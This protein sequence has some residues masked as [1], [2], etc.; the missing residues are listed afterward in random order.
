M[1][2][3]YDYIIVGAGSAGCVL[4]NRLSSCGRN[5]V[6][7]V[8]AGPGDD[9]LFIKMPAAFTQAMTKGR[10]DWGYETEPE[11]HLNGRS[12]PCYR[13]RVMGGSSSINAMSFVRGHPADYDAWASEHGL[14]DWSYAKCLPYFKKLETYSEGANEFR[15]G[16]GP[17]NVT[18][19]KLSSPLQSMFL[20]AA[21][22]AGYPTT[23]DT[24]G[25]EQEGFGLNDQMIHNGQRV[26]AATAYI[27]PIKSRK[28]LRIEMGA[29]VEHVLFKNHRAVGIE[30]IQDGQ[31]KKAFSAM[32][33][34]LSAGAINSPKL[35][36][37]SGIGPV[38]HL[39]SLGIDVIANSTEV[40]QNLQDHVDFSIAHEATRPITVSP[41]LRFPKKAMIGI[42]WIL[43]KTGWGATNHFET[44]GYV[45]TND[46][47]S[48]PNV[49]FV[50]VPLLVRPDG[51]AKAR[52]HGFQVTAMLLRPRSRGTVIVKNTAP[53]HPPAIHYDY[54][55]QGGDLEELRE[56]VRRLRMILSQSALDACRGPELSP[57]PDVQS[58]D[59]IDEFIRSNLK[60]TYHPCGTCRMGIDN[61]SVVDAEARVRGV[62]GLRVIDASIFPSVTSGNIN[63][64]TLK[65]A[66]KLADAILNAR[67]APT[68]ILRS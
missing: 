27:H 55:G 2:E 67:P 52:M 7:L 44:V 30:Y 20:S 65:V 66:E 34:I 59:E 17:V 45:R 39:A 33:V 8:E 53:E 14:K 36:V 47:L 9:H 23:K 3:T 56:C 16:D 35:L 5:R 68:M 21:E 41:A 38:D 49:Q 11:Q 43:R 15:G 10:F 22:Q 50:L 54:L 29:M 42:E 32:E 57:G 31:K 28:N 19:P 48:Q 24:N 37:L 12:A 18:A 25:E 64:P 60:S 4:A 51:T 61:A 1:T 13:G 63:A 58:D 40:G 26:S 62:S 6:L 46:A